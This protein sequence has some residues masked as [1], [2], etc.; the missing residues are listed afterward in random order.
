MKKLSKRL[1]S[2][3]LAAIMAMPA[4]MAVPF[5]AEAADAPSSDFW[6]IMA[7]TDFTK[8]DTWE[9]NWSGTFNEANWDMYN[10]SGNSTTI[11][12][13][14]GNEMSWVFRRWQKSGE[15]IVNST[16][17]RSEYIGNTDNQGFL[18][19]SGYNGQN[20]NNIFKD[21]DSFKIDLEFSLFDTTKCGSDVSNQRRSN[22]TPIIKL[23]TD[24][25]YKY[26]F[27]SRNTYEYEY[28]SQEVWGRRHF[29]GTSQTNHNNTDYGVD[30][31]KVS[32][33][34]EGG[35]YAIST[36]NSNI[37]VNT[38]Y[39]YVVY[40]ANGYLG[41]YLSD[42]DGNIVINYSAVKLSSL[43]GFSASP[44]DITGIYLGNSNGNYWSNVAYKSISIYKGV[45]SST[46]DTTRNNYLYAYFTGDSDA[47]ETMHYAISQD[48][49][50]FEAVNNG[51]KVW[52]PAENPATET[53]PT[54]AGANSTTG[55]GIS[56]HVRDSY[57]FIGQNG[58]CYV[59]ATDLDTKNGKWGSIENSRFL[60]WEM[61]SFAD[62]P[63]T[64]PWSIDTARFPEMGT[65]TGGNKVKKAWAPQVIW[66]SAAQKYMI[67]WSVGADGIS[68][69]IY[70][71]YSSDLK[72]DFTAPKRLV[73]PD[74]AASGIANHID[75]D[76]TYHN[77]LYYLWFKNEDST[78]TGAKRVW[79]AVAPN[80]NGP[81]SGFTLFETGYGSE[82][83]QV[84]QLSQNSYVLMVDGYGDHTYHM[85]PA[86]DPSSFSTGNEVT[87]NVTSLTPR[88]GSI[89]RISNTEYNRLKNLKTG[90][91]K[92]TWN[93]PTTAA[94]KDW[95]YSTDPT[96]KQYQVSSTSITASNG[97]L[98][99]NGQN[100]F[101]N[102]TDM[103]SIVMSG[104]Y[105]ITF[106]HQLTDANKKTDSFTA[107]A[108]GNSSPND[109][110]KLTESGKFIVNGTTI[111][112]G[113]EVDTTVNHKYTITSNGFITSL[114]VDGE[115]LCGTYNTTSID[116]GGAG[117]LYIGIGWT[118]ATGRAGGKTTATYGPLTILPTS[119]PTGHEDEFYNSFKPANV[120]VGT[121]NGKTYHVGDD[122]TGGYRN[123]VWADS[124]TNWGNP[125][126]GDK[127]WGI[128]RVQW[129]PAVS[130]NVVLA[131]T[132]DGSSYYPIQMQTTREKDTKYISI[133]TLNLNNYTD[134]YKLQNDQ[135]YGYCE[136]WNKWSKNNITYSTSFSS[137]ANVTNNDDNPHESSNQNSSAHRLWW[138]IVEYKGTG[139]TDTYYDSA[140]NLEFYGRTSYKGGGLFDSRQYKTGTVTS[141]GSSYVINYKPIHDILN[142]TTKVP[143]T[144][145]SLTIS[146][147]FANDAKNRW[148]YTTDSYVQAVYAM[149]LL[150]D[151]N[152]NNYNYS[153]DVAGQVAKC[154]Q[155]IKKAIEEFNKINLVKNNFAITYY[156]ANG[157][158]RA[159]TIE[160]G[161]TLASV[162]G[163]TSVFHIDGTDKHMANIGWSSVTHDD[164]PSG[165]EAYNPSV[166][167][168]AS[169]MPKANTVYTESGTPTDCNHN[170]AQTHV[171]ATEELNGY[172]DYAC[173]VCDNINV[174][175]RAWD[176]HTAEWATY[177]S[178][179][180]AVSGNVA[181]TG[182][183]T[184]SRSTYQ[185]ECNTI[186]N[187]VTA[188]D[189]T[190]PVSIINAKNTAFDTAEG[191]LDPCADVATLN[192]SFN[193]AD[194]FLKGIEGQ[195]ATYTEESI[196]AII[197]ALGANGVST[198][199]NA[200]T[201]DL[202]RK[203]YQTTIDNLESAI[204]TAYEGREEVD[205]PEEAVT[206]YEAA[207]EK[208]TNL[209]PDTYEENEGGSIASA[210]SGA[211]ALFTTVNYAGKTIN[212]VADRVESVD[213]DNAITTMLTALRNCV[214]MYNISTDSG[215]GEISANNGTYY[216]EDNKSPFG[217]KLNFTAKDPETVWYLKV[218]SGT[219]HRK[220][221]FQGFGSRLEVKTVG[222]VTVTTKTR[223]ANQ[224]RVRITRTYD[225]ATSQ[226][227]QLVDFVDDSF[228]LPA[229]PAIAYYNFSGY[230]LKGSDERLDNPS[231][232]YPQN[233]SITADTEIVAKY[234]YNGEASCAVNATTL[235]GGSVSKPDAVAYNSRIDLKGGNNAYGWSVDLGNGNY[236]PFY[237]GADLTMYATDSMNLVAED[238]ETFNAHGYA[239]PNIYLRSGTVTSGTKTIFN[240]QVVAVDMD[241]VKESGILVAVANGKQPGSAETVDPVVPTASEVT[242]ENSGQQTGFAVL[243]AKSTK[244]VG[245]NQISIAVN[246][247]PNG[248][249]YRGYVIY[250]DKDGNLQTVYT[251]VR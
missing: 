7:S 30:G 170:T 5:S 44:S 220:N 95:D 72:S 60:V 138:N 135:W 43:N 143:N 79:R 167:P 198:Y 184:S 31:A 50:N 225:N 204:S 212:V 2:L 70:Y 201:S 105:T 122:M 247:L 159:E 121:F 77:G 223:G 183:T 187:G 126:N 150:S 161:N 110:V 61:D 75:A 190:I 81:Y 246:N 38:T 241:K 185:S 239:L 34:V 141:V 11:D 149:K 250:Q 226:A 62:I 157:T 215:V 194:S 74:F 108:I 109:F 124:G 173:S 41:G 230:Y 69:Q 40:V 84:Y 209:D 216:I 189:V 94:S 86:D 102:D 89:V 25:S 234:T 188:N 42:A 169:V 116:F 199:Y 179:A 163:A 82:G 237:V 117:Y 205:F 112:S 130:P 32:S 160:A 47:G 140:T 213:M 12:G 103:R 1:L 147:L 243:R 58:K 219:M 115:Y 208:I 28:F 191:K 195:D 21:V 107:L 210:K 166:T 197:D 13:V 36:N 90:G 146:Q 238:E 136:T 76:I 101:I 19:L 52:D 93:T 178:H 128:G 55:V 4:V 104:V 232:D 233:I 45:D 214:K 24:N 200:D 120:N 206:G 18:F 176:Q 228:G 153:S 119:T 224:K 244:Y 155:D 99:M 49:V 83:P 202:S 9:N 245:A 14:G 218:D 251:D 6:Q 211:E 240:A 97:V 175:N 98:S 88:H 180:N 53:F 27:T 125:S 151:C 91:V 182:Y 162:P 100:V 29:A 177:V 10:S 174:A 59:I 66:D 156:L 221:A 65:I 171:A 131:Y 56:N 248:Y 132:G 106:S 235:E 23:A 142:G 26:N 192:S 222:N 152:P 22:Y 114:L 80:A 154:G 33:P 113:K 73:Y 168:S 51:T 54:T 111:N 92:Y 217:T 231:N 207:Y 17:V 87:T 35:S 172:T 227:I 68:T 16:G 67:Y 96:G 37:S 48:G 158:M 133:H 20:T 139:N 127:F 229:S 137:V 181:D 63:D 3:M 236:R 39:H 165:S 144:N 186:T 46:F 78:G 57:A 129:K 64:K 145:N 193:T 71:S 196:H 15:P 134:I 148:M 118:D 203:T 242:V 123:I 8:Y 164:L 249:K 85:Y